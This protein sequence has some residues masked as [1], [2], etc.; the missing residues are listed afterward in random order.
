MQAVVDELVNEPIAPEPSARPLKQAA[1]DLA[2]LYDA[3]SRVIYY[4]CLRL[5]GDPQKAED[6]THDVFLKAW[7][8]MDQFEGRSTWRTWLYRVA[9]NHC[10][11]LQNRW[12]GRHVLPTDNEHVLE[13]TVVDHASPLRVIE[14]KELGQ[15]IQH[16]LDQ[17]PLEYRVLLLLVADQELSYA[18]VAGLTE[19]STDAV[20]GKL[21][22][23]RKM[24]A[25][26]FPKTA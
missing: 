23:A 8:R 24:F 19:Q 15:R 26:E 11:N 1:P 6:A 3:H 13:D 16:T 17:L 10:R 7:H 21:H 25:A 9:I 4:L 18:E 20:R 5:L 12:A 22:R 2:A 14:I